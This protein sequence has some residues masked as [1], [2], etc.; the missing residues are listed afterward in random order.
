MKIN[1]MV[2]KNMRWECVERFHFTGFTFWPFEEEKTKGKIKWTYHQLPF[3]SLLILIFGFSLLVLLFFLHSIL[4]SSS[5][6]T[7][8]FKEVFD[9]N[10]DMIFCCWGKKK[11]KEKRFIKYYHK[12]EEELFDCVYFKSCFLKK[13]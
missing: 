8:V 2:W 4:S 5:F 11:S 10:N 7:N 9:L 12:E 3:F 6:F 1:S 13:I